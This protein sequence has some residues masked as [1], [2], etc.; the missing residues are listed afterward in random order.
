M[1]R[2]SLGF[3]LASAVI[4]STG[5]AGPSLD[6]DAERWVKRTIEKMTLDQKIGQVLVPS[7]ES[8]YLAT[9]TDIFEQLAG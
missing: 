2:A 9:D 7:F 4:A 3:L 8:M 1:I 6:R 5:A